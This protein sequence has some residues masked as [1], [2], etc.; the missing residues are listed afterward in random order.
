MLEEMV[1]EWQ[2]EMDDRSLEFSIEAPDDVP[3]VDV[4]VRRMRWAVINLVRN[5]WQNTPEGGQIRVR[6]GTSDHQVTLSV[7][8]TGFG[9]P[10]EEQKRL[11]TRFYRVTRDTEDE[12]RGMGIGLYVA[13]AI[14]EAH[15]GAIEV[16]SEEGT[17]STF[18]IVLPAIQQA[19]ETA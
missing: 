9:I 16:E 7:I 10:T 8:D 14:V 2:Q 6:L 11:F 5:A 15:G 19:E 17:G 3:E 1:P 12:A 13:K 18:S 4:D